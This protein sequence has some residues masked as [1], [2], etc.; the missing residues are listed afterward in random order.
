MEG[1]MV[2]ICLKILKSAYY[3]QSVSLALRILKSAPS[4]EKL[5]YI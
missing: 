5:L 4:G 3:S 2:L 1:K